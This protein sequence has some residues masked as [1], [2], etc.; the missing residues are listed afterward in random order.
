VRICFDLPLFTNDSLG[1]R[2]LALQSRRL[3]PQRFPQPLITNKF[4]FTHFM[5]KSLG[6][7]SAR[8]CE[9]MRSMNSA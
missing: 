5:M 1:V 3:I 2:A 9:I 7:T 4:D 6:M 8:F